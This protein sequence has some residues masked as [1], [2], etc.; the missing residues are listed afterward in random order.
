MKIMKANC[1]NQAPSR[2]SSDYGVEGMIDIR[3]DP[4]GGVEKQK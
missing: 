3:D 2:K 1:R 4:G